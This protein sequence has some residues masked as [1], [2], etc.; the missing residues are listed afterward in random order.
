MTQLH[1][2]FSYISIAYLQNLEQFF[3]SLGQVLEHG[4]LLLAWAVI[5]ELGVKG[6]EQKTAAL[7]NK[8]LGVKVFP[9]LVSR[10]K[11]EPFCG[12]SVSDYVYLFGN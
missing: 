2:Q 10:L 1:I 7:G 11:S 3:E 4:P 5:R 9:Y 6:D 8:A 12:N